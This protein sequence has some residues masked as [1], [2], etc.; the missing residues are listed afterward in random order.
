MQRISVARITNFA[1]ECFIFN[2][3]LKKNEIWIIYVFCL[4][5]IA[6]MLIIK[7]TPN[8]VDMK[9]GIRVFRDFIFFYFT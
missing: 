1:G 6:N 2:L 5:K 7:K 9:H 8:F 3:H 4:L